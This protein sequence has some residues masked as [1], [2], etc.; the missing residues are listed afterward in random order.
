MKSR[1]NNARRQ[2]GVK[3]TKPY[4][5]GNM[6]MENLITPH[7]SVNSFIFRL[8]ELMPDADIRHGSFARLSH[9]PRMQQLL[10]GGD[11]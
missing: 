5:K 1:N 4:L 11:Q 3:S 8:E 7:F 10:K 9:T 2:P 6:N